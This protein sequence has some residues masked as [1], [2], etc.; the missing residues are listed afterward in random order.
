MDI[1]LAKRTPQTR[2]PRP[3]KNNLNDKE[4]ESAFRSRF[5]HLMEAEEKDEE[6]RDAD[7]QD[8][9]WLSSRITTCMLH[10]AEETLL[11]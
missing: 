7:A 4:V 8:R 5:E 3:D 2:G 6:D 9:N 10:A 11:A 1:T